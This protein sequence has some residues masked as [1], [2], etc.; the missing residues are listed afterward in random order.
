MK[1]EIENAIAELCEALPNRVIVT[2]LTGGNIKTIVRDCSLAGSPYVQ[3]D[4]W[5]GFTITFAHPLADIYPHFVRSDL[6]RK[7]GKPFGQGFHPGRPLG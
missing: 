6:A 1:S 2:E 5:C 7:D 4:T 3:A